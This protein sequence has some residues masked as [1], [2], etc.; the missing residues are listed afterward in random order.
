M[1]IKRKFEVDISTDTFV[2]HRN[3]S[4]LGSG[5]EYSAY[6]YFRDQPGYAHGTLG[7]QYNPMAVGST[8]GQAV[9][10]LVNGIW[11]IRED[12]ND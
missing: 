4:Q 8:P 11:V 1:K 10:N 12:P 3:G 5:E 6:C 9:D 2:V 7:I